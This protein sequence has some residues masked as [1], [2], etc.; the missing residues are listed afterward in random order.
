MSI[1]ER[2]ESVGFTPEE[3]LDLT[4]RLERAAEQEENM[5]SATKRKI[6]RISGG[7]VFGVA[8]AVMMTAG[9]LA[10]VLNP[11]LRGW[12]DTQTPGGQETLEKSIYKLDRSQTYNGWTVSLK[13]CV[14]DD[15]SVY[16]L[17]EATAPEGTVLARP[18]NGSITLI[19]GI[20]TMGIGA[21]SYVL[22]DEDPADN[23]ISAM[24]DASVYSTSEKLRG[25]TVTISIDPI[26]D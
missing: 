11:G 22:E 25:K 17:V 2:F 24:L 7:M 3:K 26:V 16:I 1:K 18:E 12:F 6:K 21:S 23:R 8:A 19:G 9:A 20:D 5:T 15:S 4:A 10:A 14:G 13:E